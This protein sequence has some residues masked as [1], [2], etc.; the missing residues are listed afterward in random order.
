M[1]TITRYIITN[2]F[3]KVFGYKSKSSFFPAN[4]E[5]DEF[6]RDNNTRKALWKIR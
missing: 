6:F 1:I 3:K 2:I 5:A 4:L